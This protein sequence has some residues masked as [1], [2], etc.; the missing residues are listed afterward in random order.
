[1]KH[2]RNKEVKHH[3]VYVKELATFA[4]KTPQEATPPSGKDIRD[5]S[6][7]LPS[8]QIYNENWHSLAT[9]MCNRGSREIKRARVKQRI[10][11]GLKLVFF[12]LFNLLDQQIY[13]FEIEKK[14]KNSADL[15]EH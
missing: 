6:G 4:L 14:K 12:A 1:M 3:S 9:K 11:V 2:L 13:L 8:I 7:E 5:R 10:Y 15:F